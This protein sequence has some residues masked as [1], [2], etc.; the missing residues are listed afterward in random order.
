M[1]IADSDSIKAGEKELISSI[2]E[3]LNPETLS[4]VATKNMSPD[5]MEFVQG[6]MMIWDNRIVYKMNFKATLDISVMFDRNG[7][8]VFTDRSEDINASGLSDSSDDMDEEW[9][10][11]QDHVDTDT[12]DATAFEEVILSD[13]APTQS[14][15]DEMSDVF[16]RTRE[17]W[18]KKTEEA[19]GSANEITLP[20]GEPDL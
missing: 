14:P 19:L 20:P 5:Q 10:H 1:K 13:D 12:M 15:D 16:S 2:M 17:F 11:E 7:E 9:E 6:D 4:R 18:N 8:L 3:K